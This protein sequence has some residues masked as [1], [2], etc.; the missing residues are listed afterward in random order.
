MHIFSVSVRWGGPELMLIFNGQAVRFLQA[1][2]HKLIQHVRSIQNVIAK[3]NK[4]FF[5]LYLYQL[6]ICN[7][8]I[9]S[10]T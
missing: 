5:Q 4:A 1:D 9:K 8:H 3:L 6:I 10:A 7:H 2:A